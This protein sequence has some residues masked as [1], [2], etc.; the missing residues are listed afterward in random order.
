MKRM[1]KN[2]DLIDVEPDGT[3]TVAGKPIGGGGGNERE[4]TLTV[5]YNR[6]SRP[7]NIKIYV[8]DDVWNNIKNLY[9]DTV[10]IHYKDGN[11]MAIFT[12]TYI[13][14]YSFGKFDIYSMKYTSLA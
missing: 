13:S 4:I 9:Y 6:E 10:S 2:G 11:P 14:T 1:V 8:E 3:I 7:N 5:S 12:A